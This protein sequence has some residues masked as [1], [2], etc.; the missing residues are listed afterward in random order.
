MPQDVDIHAQAAGLGLAQWD[1]AT[2]DLSKVWADGIARI[3]RLAAAAPWGHDSAG[4][5]FQTAY[6][7]DG[8][9]DRMHQ[10][11]DRIMKDIAALGAKVRTAVTRSRDTDSQTTETIRS[12]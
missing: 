7:K 6:T 12:I 3:Q 1:T 11:G 5:N 10:D 8:G 9:P 2:A 4:T